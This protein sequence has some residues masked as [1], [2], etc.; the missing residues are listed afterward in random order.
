VKR[1]T[2]RETRFEAGVAGLAMPDSLWRIERATVGRDWPR[3]DYIL[4]VTVGALLVIGMM[5]VYSAT[6][7][8]V[9]QTK[10]Q[11]AWYLVRQALWVLLGLALLLALARLDYAHLHRISIPLMG[12]MALLLIL[13][14]FFGQERYGAV[15]TFANGSL[16]P[17]ELTKLAVVIY[18]ADWLASKGDKIR[19]VSYGLIP[20]GVLVGGIGGLIVLEPDL[21]TAALVVATAVTMFFLAGAEWKQLIA[22]GGIAALTFGALMMNSAHAKQRIADFILMFQNPE[23]AG[24]QVQQAFVSIGSGGVFGRGLGAGR[25]KLGYLPLPHTD[26][27]FAVIGEETGLIGCLVVVALFAVLAYRGYKIAAQAP[28]VFGALLAAGATSWLVFEAAFNIAA[29]TGLVPFTGIPL[30]FISYGGSALVSAMGAVGVLLSVSRGTRKR[31][32][33]SSATND[34]GRRDGRPRLSRARSR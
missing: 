17:S 28:D 16:Q 1:K 6:F 8:L 13:V 29:M 19:D 5:M 26:S 12:V 24:W 34:F 31:A 2:E 33:Q 21:S 20:F 30:P 23:K 22:G 9:N 3:M 25:L 14:L 15:R 11:P 32:R 10:G 18:I 7:D 4:A 27:I